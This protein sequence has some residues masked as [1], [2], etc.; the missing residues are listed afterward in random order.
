MSADDSVASTAV[1]PRIGTVTRKLL[2]KVVAVKYLYSQN[3]MENGTR[4]PTVPAVV[5]PYP[6]SRTLSHHNVNI[7]EPPRPPSS[8]KSL[9]R[10][11]YARRRVP[12]AGGHRGAGRCAR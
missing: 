1:M 10:Q 8:P 6:T 3:C 9:R 4:Y 7:N 11:Q 12:G 5:H 2:T